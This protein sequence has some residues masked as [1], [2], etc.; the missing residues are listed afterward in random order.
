MVF[1]SCLPELLH[2]SDRIRVCRH[3]RIVGASG[4]TAAFG[5]AARRAS[6]H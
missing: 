5:S 2:S 6:V 1:S 4:G 3:G